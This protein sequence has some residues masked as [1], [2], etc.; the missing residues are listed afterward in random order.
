MTFGEKDRLN[1]IHFHHRFLLCRPKRLPLLPRRRSLRRAPGRRG[2]ADDERAADAQLDKDRKA[3][4][5]V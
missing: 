5:K 4:E 3:R 1:D 2:R